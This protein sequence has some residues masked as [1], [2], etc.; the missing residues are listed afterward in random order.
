MSPLII[1][2]PSPNYNDRKLPISM[3]VLHYTGMENGTAALD[4]MRDPDAQ[5]SAHY[6]IEE[7][8]RVFRL[9]PEANRAWHAGVSDWNGIKDVNSASIGIEIVNGGHEFGL[10][11]FPDVQINALIP[12]CKRIVTAHNIAQQNIVGHSDIAPER[13]EDP[14]EM[15][16]W[17]GLAAAGIGLWPGEANGDRRVLF[18]R[19]DRDRG[20]SLIQR[21]LAG[22]GYGVALDGVMTDRTVAVIRAFQRRYRAD[23]IDGIVDMETLDLVSRLAR[24]V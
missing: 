18:E 24:L 21:G 19:G 4:R 7:D 23:K 13:K 1:E 10:P 8:G 6:M 16:P 3:L 15:F 20:I 12:L 14:G 22:L 9:V 2:T 5:V 11:D 17:T